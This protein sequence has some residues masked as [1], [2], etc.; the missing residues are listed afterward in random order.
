MGKVTQKN[1]EMWIFTYLDVCI[2][3]LNLEQPS[4]YL[5]WSSVIRILSQYYYPNA[6]FTARVSRL[7]KIKNRNNYKQP[8]AA[9]YGAYEQTSPN[10]QIM[11]NMNDALVVYKTFTHNTQTAYDTTQSQL[12][13]WDVVEHRC[14]HGQR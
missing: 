13:N 6:V 7:K 2:N 14:C 8:S 12:Q 1:E 5:L 9:V 10:V 3:S 11:K 4:T